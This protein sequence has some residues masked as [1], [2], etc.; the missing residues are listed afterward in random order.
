[1]KSLNEIYVE[2]VSLDDEEE[3]GEFYE[4]E[5]EQD[6]LGAEY[7]SDY[8]QVDEEK[9]GIVNTIID[10]TKAIFGRLNFEDEMVVQQT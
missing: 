8:Y 5:V 6:V 4:P 3:A 9:K 1:M 7:I 2:K 10:K